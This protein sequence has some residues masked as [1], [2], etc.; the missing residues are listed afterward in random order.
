MECGRAKVYIGNCPNHLQEQVCVDENYAI[1]IPAGTWH[2][3]VN[4]GRYPL[5][6][7][8]LYAPPQHPVGTVHPTKEDAEHEGIEEFTGLQRSKK[9][10]FTVWVSRSYVFYAFMRL[11]GIFTNRD[12]ATDRCRENR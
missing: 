7:Y 6:L 10:R 4:T 1:L 2:N 5:K 9:E 11:H 12:R 3:I 8:S